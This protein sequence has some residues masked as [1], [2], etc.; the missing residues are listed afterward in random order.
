MKIYFRMYIFRHIHKHLI[1]VLNANIDPTLN[2]SFKCCFGMFVLKMINSPLTSQTSKAKIR[3]A[4][5]VMDKAK[6]NQPMS[7]SENEAS[8]N[9][10]S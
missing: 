10:L 6:Q 3:K 7:M 9:C 4:V 2:R 1:P 8:F 5:C